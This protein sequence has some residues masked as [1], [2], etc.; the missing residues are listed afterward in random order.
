ML[1][2]VLLQLELVAPELLQLLGQASAAPVNI[3]ERL[4]GRLNTE[5]PVPVLSVENE[6]EDGDHVVS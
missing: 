5:D 4:E 3:E 1:P 2:V 6:Y